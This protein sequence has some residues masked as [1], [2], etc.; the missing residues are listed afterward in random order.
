MWEGIESKKL[1][2]KPKCGLQ[3]GVV[4]VNCEEIVESLTR[5]HSTYHPMEADLTVNL[6]GSH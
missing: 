4:G 5:K 2:R 1:S 3:W 6:A